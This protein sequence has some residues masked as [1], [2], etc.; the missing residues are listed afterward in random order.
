MSDAWDEDEVV[1]TKA[2][3]HSLFQRLLPFAKPHLGL[4]VRSFGVLIAVFLLQL[5]STDIWRRALDGPVASAVEAGADTEAL[6]SQLLGW[7]AIYGVILL[8]MVFLRYQETA[9]LTRT[10]Q[11]VIHDLRCSVFRHIQRMDLAFFDKQ[12]TGSLVTRVTTDI[13]HLNEM[14]TS[15]LISLCFDLVKVVVVLA[16]L[17]MIDVELA[18]LVT[19]MTPLLIGISIAFRGGARRAHRIVRAR[20]ARLNGYLQEILS[21]I[22]VVQMFRREKR[23]SKRFGNH[24]DNYYQANKRTIFLFAL[25]YPSMSFAVHL[26]QVAT[27]GFGV[28]A[29]RNGNLSY[30]DFFQFWL[31]LDMLVRPIRELGERYNILQS[32]FASAE[33]LFQVLDTEATISSPAEPQP[34]PTAGGPGHLRFENV[35]FGYLDGH[36]VTKGVTFD[37]PPGKTV[38]LVGATGSGKSTLVNLALRFY[39]P[40]E[41]KV[42]VDGVD[43]RDLDLGELRSHFGLVLQE[44]Y[45]FAGT[46]RQNLVMGR[47][48]LDDERLWSALRTSTADRFVER[49]DG[50]LEAKVAERG[51]TFSTGE[52][53]LLAISRALAGQPGVVV[54]DEATASVDSASEA[55]IERATAELLAG[56]SALVVAHRLSTIRDADEILVMDAGEIQERGRH[57]ELLERGGIY[58][59]LYELQF[60]KSESA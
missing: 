19:V 43:V 56:R 16:I 35:T 31:L 23:V 11:A 26:I 28:M 15:G 60:T 6:T 54:L 29:I 18:L 4:F 46:V 55:R 14:F 52:R 34:M 2:W 27:I 22:R 17:Y 49:L 12:P 21:G 10:G 9:M 1:A 24:L 37:V 48:G 58:A 36:P 53:Q 25:F 33:R 39:D 32:A 38:A 13:E 47:E 8:I 59:R 7:L 40:W 3:D 44:D 20:L 50:G 57:D 42:T 45:L 5:V 41:G 51:A 30:G